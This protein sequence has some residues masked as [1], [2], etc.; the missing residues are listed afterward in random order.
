MLADPEDTGQALEIMLIEDSLLDARVTIES[1]RDCGIHNRLSLFRHGA[2]AVDF[3]HRRGVFSKAPRPHVILLDLFLPDTE[4]VELLRQFRSDPEI[5]EIP[6]VILTSSDDDTDQR[7]CE[8]LGVSS[9]IRKP[10]NEEKFLSVI[11]R[12]KG[13]SLMLTPAGNVSAY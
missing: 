10:F 13:L 6:V 12:L 2:E 3:L 8:E 5:A 7:R 11:R 9:Y 4:G 1:L